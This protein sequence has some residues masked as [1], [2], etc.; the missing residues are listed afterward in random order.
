MHFHPNASRLAPSR[1]PID[2]GPCRNP[3]PMSP[4]SQIAAL[5]V[6]VAW[7]TEQLQ[8]QLRP[9]VPTK[10][11]MTVPE[12]AARWGRGAETI[13]RM[14]RKKELRTVRGH[15]P[16]EIALAEVFRFEAG[17]AGRPPLSVSRP[18]SR[19]EGR[20]TN[21]PIQTNP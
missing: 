4:D 14:I 9:A 20:L 17:T 2:T 6:Q 5:T 12:L 18:G 15:R 8:A 3:G 10:M 1:A 21:E 13:R 19:S 16:Y 7:L 11:V